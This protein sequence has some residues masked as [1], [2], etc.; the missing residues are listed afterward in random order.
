MWQPHRGLLSRYGS[1][2]ASIGRVVQDYKAAS[3]RLSWHD[4]LCGKRSRLAEALL[5]VVSPK[6]WR[7]LCGMPVWHALGSITESEAAGMHY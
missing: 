2:V 5:A 4:T 3:L 6:V 1:D 7:S